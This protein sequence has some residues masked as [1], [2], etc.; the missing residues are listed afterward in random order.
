MGALR[1]L[2]SQIIPRFST[3]RVKPSPTRS[4][5]LRGLLAPE[6]LSLPAGEP[7]PPSCKPL[8]LARVFG[9]AQL[10]RT[11]PRPLRAPLTPSRP[12][13]CP[14]VPSPAAEGGRARRGCRAGRPADP[15]RAGSSCR[16]AHLQQRRQLPTAHRAVEP[17][18]G[19]QPSFHHA[20][21]TAN[22]PAL[23]TSST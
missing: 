11:P 7:S 13:T 8:L 20:P 5:A 16:S 10:Y 17:A 23:P 22:P 12:D 4:T 15:S 19:G 3:R 2:P 9:P 6:V 14:A 18:A 21:A 1:S